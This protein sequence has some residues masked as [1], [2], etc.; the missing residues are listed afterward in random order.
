MALSSC[1]CFHCCFALIKIGVCVRDD[2]K[3]CMQEKSEKRTA[4]LSAD[5]FLQKEA[6]FERKWWDETCLRWCNWRQAH[7]LEYTVLDE[8]AHLESLL[9]HL[10][11]MFC[12][13]SVVGI[14]MRA[15]FVSGHSVIISCVLLHLT[16]RA[17]S[18]LQSLGKEEEEDGGRLAAEAVSQCLW[19][20]NRNNSF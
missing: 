7:S 3:P 6:H 2:C 1:Y 18:S 9:S 13:H 20:T 5:H 19:S 16:G 10:F 11:A 14:D 12:E 15:A 4:T 17:Y 8:V